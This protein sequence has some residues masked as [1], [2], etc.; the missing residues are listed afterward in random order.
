MKTIALLILTCLAVGCTF[1]M[2]DFEIPEEG[3]VNINVAIPDSGAAIEDDPSNGEADLEKLIEEKFRV[4]F[5]QY[6]SG[7]EVTEGEVLEETTVVIKYIE[8]PIEEEAQEDPEQEEEPDP[9]EDPVDGY[10]DDWMPTDEPR[11]IDP[12]CEMLIRYC[13]KPDPDGG[14]LC[15]YDPEDGIE[16]CGNGVDD[17]CDGYTDED[18]CH[19]PRS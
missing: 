13:W 1:E 4:A 19:G 9:E 17:D 7:S 15:A 5:E 16:V 14:R 6:E 18:D 2:P 10:P 12:E 8:V 11:Y 3:L